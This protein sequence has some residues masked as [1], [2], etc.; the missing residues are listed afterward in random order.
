MP[1][2]TIL[3]ALSRA[4]SPVTVTLSERWLLNITID[5]LDAEIRKKESL[6]TRA[7]SSATTRHLAGKALDGLRVARAEFDAARKGS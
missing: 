1:D 5:A 6:S 4:R 3:E 7:G 2:S